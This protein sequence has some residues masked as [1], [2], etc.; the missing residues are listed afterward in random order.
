MVV[1]RVGVGEDGEPGEHCLV[2]ERQR[3]E[4]VVS[5]KRLG[6]GRWSCT[7][8]CQHRLDLVTEEVDEPVA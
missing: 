8:R 5:G 4:I 3:R 2:A 1:V 7:G 6:A